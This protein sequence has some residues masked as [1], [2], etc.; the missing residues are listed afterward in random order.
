MNALVDDLARARSITAPV[1]HPLDEVLRFLK[2]FVAYPNVHAAIAHALW[3]THTHL[4]EAWD[5][6]PRIAFL[7]PE[8][9]SGKSRA[10]EITEPLVPRPVQ[11]VN[12]TPAYLFRKVGA[13]EG[14]PTVLYD[15]IDTVFGPKVGQQN[16]EIR[17]LL[18]AGHRKHSKAGR[19]VKVRGVIKTEEYSAY[20][21]VAL[22]GLGD[23]PDTVLTRSV[24][25]RMR[26]R[27]P[28]DTIEPYRQREHAEQ[29]ALLQ[30]RIDAWTARILNDM[31]AARPDMPEGV[32]DRDADKWE[33]LLAIA[34]AAGGDWPEQARRAAV[35]FVVESKQSTPSLGLRLLTDL[36]EVF[37]DNEAM[38]TDRIISALCLIDEA[39]W[40]DLRGK[41]IDARGLAHRLKK[42][43]ITSR[44]LRDG[45]G[46]HKGY[47]RADMLDAWLRYLPALPSESATSATA[48]QQPRR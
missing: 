8:P 7:S 27:A 31:A 16:E 38:A 14:L 19:C 22:A 25:V 33:P 35:W 34:D 42:Y 47:A 24:V 4:M 11:A 28:D 9:G 41:P 18:N 48:L 21:A 44:N 6:T 1:P 23:L 43:G 30:E 15:E 3:I 39:P 10:L 36:R 37:G 32:V 2:R 12:V 5:S 45:P 20:C 26:R 13:E 46:V 40:G 17:A 29:A